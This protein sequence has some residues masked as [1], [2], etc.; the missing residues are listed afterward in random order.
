[1]PIGIAA[2][3]LVMLAAAEMRSQAGPAPAR[4]PAAA[5]ADA[6]SAACR[7]DQAAFAT[8]LT[9]ANSAAFRALPEPQRSALLKRFVLLDDAGRPLLSTTAEGRTEVRCEAAGLVSDMRLGSAEVRENLAFVTA[10]V[11][12][13]GGEARS[14][15][16]GLVR[17]AGEWKL[18]SV[19][20]L[21]LDLPAISRQWEEAD[22]EA[23][24]A[25]VIASLRKIAEALGKYQAGVR[26]A[27]RGPRTTRACFPGRH[28]T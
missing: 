14:V 4:D 27:A 19:G 2:I 13:P 25:E 20:L 1:M 17:E 16:I 6:L 23:R 28:L 24:E 22:L 15:R 5:L 10:E 3:L 26:Q 21:L 18:L 12:E 9:A 8:H 7:Q 11:G